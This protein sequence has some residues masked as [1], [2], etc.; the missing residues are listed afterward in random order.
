MFFVAHLDC[1]LPISSGST[2]AALFS[3][4]VYTTEMDSRFQVSLALHLKAFVANAYSK[5]IS[6]IGAILHICPLFSPDTDVHSLVMF[7]IFFR[8]KAVWPDRPGGDN[9]MDVRVVPGR[10]CLFR[11]SWM[12]AI[13]YK[14]RS[15]KFGSMKS[16]TI[17]IN[18]RVGSSL[19]RDPLNSRAVRAS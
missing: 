3:L 4:P 5:P 15:K 10:S 19:G 14:P 11:P 8:T 9:N 1:S 12:A 6:P 18:S 7:L 16:R 2:F 13:A 17:E